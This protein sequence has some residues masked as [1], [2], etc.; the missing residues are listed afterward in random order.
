MNQNLPLFLD[1]NDYKEIERKLSKDSIAKQ[2]ENNYVSLVSPTSLITKDF[3]KKDPLGIIFLG[4]KKLSALNINKDFKLED[5]YIVTKDEKNLLLF[6]EPKNKSNDTKNN[7]EFINQLN[8]IKDNLNQQYKGKT[9]V[10]YFGSPVIAVA[11]AQQIKKDIQNTVIISMTLLLILLIYYFKNIFTPLI[12]FLPTLFSALLALLI[13]YFFK[14]KVS[15]ISLSVSAILIG[16]TI[17]FALHILTHYKHSNS[18]EELY[19]DIT[20]PVILSSVT[21][22]VSFLCLIFVRSEALKDLGLFAS[23]SVIF[24]RF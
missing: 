15:A 22:A 1:E 23:L 4:I 5:N 8:E 10:N 21:T 24:L 20:Q 11:N 7:E 2:V 9:E 18:I 17:D 13:L 3:I 12:I 14:D 16:I 19:K 6:I